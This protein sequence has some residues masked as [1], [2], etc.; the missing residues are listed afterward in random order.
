MPADARDKIEQALELIEILAGHDAAGQGDC[1]H[2][3]NR[4]RQ[5][6]EELH[7]EMAPA[8][9]G[10]V[11]TSSLDPE[12]R[13]FLLETDNGTAVFTMLDSELISEVPVSKVRCA[14]EGPE[15]KD[16]GNCVLDFSRVMF[17]SSVPLGSI[18]ALN[19]EVHHRGGQLAIVGATPSV[20]DV[21]AVTRLDTIMLLCD[22]IDQ[23]LG[24]MAGSVR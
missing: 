24:R 1:A 15:L 2:V 23:A 14:L 12:R 5:L 10:H 4:L 22:T 21:F 6:L 3:V 17:L 20:R 9:A 13:H 11:N 18:I 8:S 7:D 16:L 19:R